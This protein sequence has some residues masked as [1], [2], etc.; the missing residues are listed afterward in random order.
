MSALVDWLGSGTASVLGWIVVHSL[1]QAALVAGVLVVV[2]RIVPTA[3]T[4]IRS[5]TASGALAI[6]LVL[7]VA[8][9]LGLAADWWQHTACWE[10]GEYALAQPA[11]CASHGVTPPADAV[12]RK[13]SGAR[14]VMPWAWISPGSGPLADPAESAALT[15]TPIT[16]YIATVGSVLVALALLRLLLDVYLLRRIVCR[17]ETVVDDEILA[18]L[19]RLR[20]RLRLSSDLELRVTDDVTTPAVAG[21]RSPTILL[22]RGVSRSLAPLELEWVLAHELVHVRR[23]HFTANLAQRTL[24]CL[25]VWN[26]F[27][28]WMSRQLS[29]EREAL[30][31]AAVVD[32][33]SA[34]RRRYAETLLRLEHLRTPAGAASIGLLGEGPLLRRVR[35]LAE[36]VELPR[37]VRARRAGVAGILA[38]TGMLLAAQLTARSMAASSWASMEHDIAIRERTADQGGSN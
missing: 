5:A 4:R 29:D 21:F 26:P 12:V 32:F 8:V 30:C 6:V 28:L 11:T 22:P 18:L 9:G 17:S 2:L 31:D 7:A 3:M 20:N 27:V 13:S 14:A 25:F 34:S 19:E 38:L 24:E 33:P 35:R 36:T 37:V 15:V 23:R 16:P 1:W 10:S